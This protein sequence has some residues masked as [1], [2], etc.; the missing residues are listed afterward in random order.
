M[1]ILLLFEFML[2][3]NMALAY[4]FSSASVVAAGEHYRFSLRLFAVTALGLLL[5]SLAI[6]LLQ[7]LLV[8]L[9][10]WAFL[11]IPVIAISLVL[12]LWLLGRFPS[13]LKGVVPGM[14]V[15][16]FSLLNYNSLL[17]GMSFLFSVN[18]LDFGSAFFGIVGG[19]IG[20]GLALYFHDLVLRKIEFEWLPPVLRGHPMALFSMGLVSLVILFI[21]KLLMPGL[22]ALA[23]V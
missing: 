18:H 23:K 1:S 22:E 7:F 11:R 8:D 9:T 13:L 5:I 2:I 17:M 12:F 4:G 6:Y 16:D 20:Y 10:G 15:G 14:D 21:G 19:I 3:Q